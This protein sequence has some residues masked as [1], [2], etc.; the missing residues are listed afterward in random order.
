LLKPVFFQFLLAPVEVPKNS[1]NVVFPIH[2]EQIIGHLDLL[3]HLV[4]D[5]ILAENPNMVIA[6]RRLHRIVRGLDLFSKL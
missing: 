2:V 3:G 4:Y 5:F 6:A 1:N